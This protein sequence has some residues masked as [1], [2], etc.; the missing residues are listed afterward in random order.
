MDDG[1]TARTVAQAAQAL[2][3]Q[4]RRV[5]ASCEQCGREI[6]G[7]RAKRYCSSACRMRASRARQG[8]RNAAPQAIDRELS[9][10]AAGAERLMRLIERTPNRRGL[11]S[12]ALRLKVLIDILE[13]QNQDGIESIHTV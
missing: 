8:G 11:R 10:L 1:E 13:H 3:Q 5:S 7:I 4:R 9:E 2:A 12:E 6:E